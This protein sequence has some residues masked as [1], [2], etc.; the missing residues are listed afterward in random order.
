M[1]L[2]GERQADKLRL[3]RVQAGGL[4]VESEQWRLAQLLQPEVETGLVEN[5]LVPGL[6]LGHRLRDRRNIVTGVGSVTLHLGDPALEFHLGVQRQQRFAIRFA[7]HQGINFDI[8]GHV[9]LDGSQLIRQERRVAVLFQ[10][11]RQG[12][13]A[14]NGQCRDLVQV[15][16]Q[17]AEATA[18]TGK[19]AHRGFFAHPRYTGDV[20]DL[21]AHQRQEVDDM[22]R[23]DAKFLVHASHVQHASGHGVDQ[24]N[25]PVHQLRHVLVTGRDDHR[26]A[27][28]GA[29]ARQGADHV[30]GLDPLDA[31]QRVAQRLDAGVQRLD[32]HPQVVRH[33]W[34]VGL[35]FGEHGIAEGATLG[36]EHHREQAVGVLLAQALEHVQHPLHRA[37]RHAFGGSQR[38]Q[39]VEGAVQV[40]GTVHQDE[41]R[42]AHEQN[43]P[44]RRVRR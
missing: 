25:V 18:D 34:A 23:A 24:G 44:F 5:G 13:G 29:A 21:V 42:L 16:I 39:R 37:G 12:L 28:R 30:V 4:G 41:G 22:F 32:L 3:L 19:Q 7:A 11:G 17:V 31:Q 43:Q 10:L 26:A 33:A 36:V 6:D 38:R 20:V 14:A 35:V 27:Q 8:Q 15:G 40:G 9:D 2:D 1:R